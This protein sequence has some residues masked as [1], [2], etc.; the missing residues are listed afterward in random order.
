MNKTK[1]SRLNKNF[2]FV[3]GGFDSGSGERQS[4]CSAND[5]LLSLRISICQLFTFAT[6]LSGGRS[7]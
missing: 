6:L 7:I 4:L 3:I 2:F 5:L 1:I